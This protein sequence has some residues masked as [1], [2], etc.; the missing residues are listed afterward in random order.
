MALLNLERTLR[1]ISRKLVGEDA[2]AAGFLSGEVNDKQGR[3][4][5]I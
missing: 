1:L 2:Q 4:A 5:D 3:D